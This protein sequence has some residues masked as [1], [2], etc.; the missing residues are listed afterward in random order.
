MQRRDF[1]KSTCVA[2]FG[3]LG[4]GSLL[5]SLQSCAP[6]PLLKGEAENGIMTIPLSSFTPEQHLLIVRNSKLDHDILLVKKT[7]GSFNAL[8]MQCTHQNQPLNASKSGLFCSAHG[9]S[10]NL[11]GQVTQEPATTPLRKFKTE[12]DTNSVKIFLSQ[13]P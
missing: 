9:S 8:Y 4:A 6:L 12:A 11:D 2:C 13:N 7:D 10:F 5:S 3:V 1:I